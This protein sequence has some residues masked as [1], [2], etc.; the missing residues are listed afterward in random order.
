MFFY[1]YF[2]RP[3]MKMVRFFLRGKAL[4][5]SDMGSSLTTH[6]KNL[7]LFPGYRP[8]K[9]SHR[10]LFA[11]LRLARFWLRWALYR[12]ISPITAE[13]ILDF[14]E[15]KRHLRQLPLLSLNHCI[16]TWQ[17]VSTTIG[18]RNHWRGRASPSL[19]ARISDSS[20]WHVSGIQLWLLICVRTL[21]KSIFGIDPSTWHLRY[22]FIASIQL[23]L[24]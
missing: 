3:C 12:R 19:R 7:Q 16:A 15:N 17:S 13:V 6:D 10:A 4:N 21:N 24:L 14:P 23:Q 20:A 9:Y 8:D 1:S 22:P 11:N 5:Y 2:C 18:L